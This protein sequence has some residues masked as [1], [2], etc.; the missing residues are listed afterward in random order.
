M[1]EEEKEHLSEIEKIRLRNI[2]E[3]KKK[4]KDLNL[5]SLKKQARV[6]IEYR[7]PQIAAKRL[8]SPMQRVW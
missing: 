4:F 3:R 8:Q 7:N 1:A 2:A 5:D 6:D